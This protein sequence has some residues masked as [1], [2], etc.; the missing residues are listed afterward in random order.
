[1]QWAVEL[2]DVQPT[3]HILEIGCGPGHAI[4]LVCA[5]LSSGTITAID[6]SEIAVARARARN[7]ACLATGRAR[8]ER[9]T[10]T[11]AN[12]GGRF[13]KI[14]AINVNAFWTTPA[15]SFAALARLLRPTGKAYLIYEPPSAARLR[16]ARDS[17]PAR[18][19]EHRFHVTDVHVQRFRA[20][21]GLCISGRVPL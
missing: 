21:Y 4:A 2:L 14:F 15:P 18:F 20:S 8:I 6:R 12:L 1:M 3:D 17:L 11:E 13:A 10:L 19:E 9:R 7:A 5:M 16:G